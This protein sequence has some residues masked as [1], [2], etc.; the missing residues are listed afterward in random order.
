MAKMLKSLRNAVL[1]GIAVAIVALS[2][3]EI[4]QAQNGSFLVGGTN[5]TS[6]AFC[7]TTPSNVG[8]PGFSVTLST[9]DPNFSSSWT[10]TVS[11]PW[12]K[13]T[14]SIGGTTPQS[15]IVSTDATTLPPNLSSGTITINPGAGSNEAPATISVTVNISDSGCGSTSG[16]LTLSAPSL[17]FN[18]AVNTQPAA[19]TLTITNQ[20]G[21][22]IS[23]SGSASSSTGF[24]SLVALGSTTVSSGQSV[25]YQVNAS[26]TGLTSGFSYS[27]SLTFTA[28]GGGTAGAVVPVTLNYG[29]TGNGGLSADQPNL[30]FGS[31]A[32]VTPGTQTITV[33]NNTSS[34][35]TINSSVASGSFLSVGATSTTTVVPNGT[36]T[37][38]VAVSITGLSSNAQ[39]SGSL[40]FTDGVGDSLLVPVTFNYGTGATSN[41]VL[42]TN[43]S[44]LAFTI[45]QGGGA[46][47]TSLL[48]SDNSINAIT[49]T[50]TT[51]TTTGQN[52]LLASPAT[53][54]VPAFNNASVT[55]TVDPSVLGNTAGVYNGTITLTASGG[56][57]TLTIPVILNY[58]GAGGTTVLTV[59]PT[60]FSVTISSGGSSVSQNLNI[61][62]TSTSNVTINVAASGSGLTISPVGQT[63][64]NAGATNQFT[65]FF[66]TATLSNGNYSGSITI[67]PVI[68]TFA[69]IT[70]P[71]TLCFG[72]T[73]TCQTGGST[74]IT[75]SPNPITITIPNG[76]LQNV[77][78]NLTVTSNVGQIVVQ[79]AAS[80]IT[81]ENWLN[82]TPSSL[83]A[84]STAT[85][86]VTISPQF[87]PAGVATG[88]ITLIPS[89]GTSLVV[90]VTVNGNSG[91]IAGLTITPAQLSFA[92]Q[93][94]TQNPPVQTLTLST[95]TASS[96]NVAATT[97]TGGSWLIVT[98]QTVTT[99]GGG[100]GSTVTV[101]VN[102]S[103]LNAGTTYSGTITLTN[104]VTGAIQSIPVSLLV[105]TLPVLTLNSSGTT[106]V[107]QQ[108]SSSFP[109]QQTVQVSS[110]GSQLS[111]SANVNLISGGN[112][113]NV[114][115]TNASTTQTLTL[116]L[117]P[118]V[119]A[120][121]TPGTYSSNVSILSASAGNSPLLYPVN[122]VVTNSTVLNA[123]QGVMNF[124]YQIGQSQPGAQTLTITSS[125]QPL[126]FAV[127]AINSNCGSFLSA[128]TPTGNT[129]GT[130]AVSVNTN[131][132][133][134]GQCTGTVSIT[135][136]G[137]ANSPLNI[138]VNLFISNTALLNVS[139]AA[140]SA[141]A[142]AGGAQ[143][144]QSVALTSTDPNN[145]ITF[146]ASVTPGSNFVRVQPVSGSTP[147]SLTLTFDPTGLAPGTYTSTLTINAA[148]PSN[149]I[150]ANAPV[151]V[152]I[153]FVVTSN[154]IASVSPTSLTFAQTFLGTPQ[155]A[156]TLQIATTT[157][158][159]AFTVIATTQ[160]AGNWLSVSP[161]SG[162]TP[163][164]VSVTANGSNLNVGTYFGSVTIQIPGAANSPINVPVTLTVGS[165]QTLV[166]NT[167]NLTFTFSSGSTP[168]P[169]TVSLAST[170]GN[171]GFT[172]APNGNPLF[173][174][175]T[176]TT[177]T[178]P[179]N[180]SISLNT[181][182]LGTLNTGSYTNQVVISSPGLVNAT[183][184]VTVTVQ[185]TQA[186]TISTILNAASLQPGA[187]APGLIVTI[188][189]AN[190]GP[191]TGVGYSVGA[192]GKMSTSVAGTT[193]TFDGV[194]S[195]LIFVRNDQINAIVPYEIGGR[196]STNVV[197]TRNGQ[198]SAGLLQTVAAT[199]P[200]IFS[201]SQ[202]GNGQGAILNFNS[203]VNGPNNPATRGSVV[204]IFCTGE[205]ALVPGVATGSFTPQFA[206][207]PKPI[208]NV[209]VTIGSAPAQTTFV[210]EA[211]TLVSGVLQVNAVVPLGAGTG[212]QTVLLTIGPNQNITQQITVYV[213]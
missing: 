98:P 14:P 100:V 123:S 162:S 61:T 186:P 183:I 64:I 163:G 128:T 122:L 112:F 203:S 132:L 63:T 113:L 184:S 141:T 208:A 42:T 91:G 41:G 173:V 129:P 188:L 160:S 84:N 142:Q 115:P 117:N 79:A 133:A 197:V 118:S 16:N 107:Y 60:S 167:P 10:T 212:P 4:A 73:G 85:F 94:L 159:Q 120:L 168:S 190:L 185:A 49:L 2:G 77:T 204:Q 156:Q 81:G 92:Y 157:A 191:T 32:N 51:S 59:N 104:T 175:V 72:T 53:Q 3:A 110:S 174:T 52:W 58:G 201:V 140:L 21:T 6:V 22:T 206:P 36:V 101:S 147:S 80:T 139:P 33:K 210:G 19:Q 30:T 182:V 28:S 194:G 102:P 57:G 152:P 45:A 131:G 24:L 144:T 71:T 148:G 47:V 35:V 96:F 192:D 87:L 172:T 202:N 213:Q 176:P 166:V 161:S 68:G 9:S 43:R 124:N 169:Q 88:S 8:P 109:A 145:Q 17:T 29:T 75:A 181:A 69:T 15:L 70:I 44:S 207:F 127:T 136:A 209:S 121:L 54:A 165:A 105:S 171:V 31:A 76:S 200:A 211:P 189:G 150:V 179:A 116:S 137:S 146:T 39:Y 5:S 135:S 149:S 83:S 62:N 199:S 198:S 89:T 187:V 97:S 26:T 13:V 126:N 23:L 25:S 138:P 193:V 38:Q 154:N 93:T 178:T 153:S 34:T 37:F 151:S 50:A 46:Q 205:G 74:T 55:I 130:V 106:F 143:Q 158:G 65:V 18:A 111:F 90:P 40:S 119:L 86:T 1:C 99:L 20:T 12:I 180:L 67:T 103:G 7:G 155:A 48:V 78:Q 66:N 170:G 27:G 82:V 11:Q 95:T 164:S 114:T 56:Q 195:P 177:G 134:V 125:G 196:V 108:G